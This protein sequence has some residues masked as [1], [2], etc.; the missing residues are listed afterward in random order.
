[1][2]TKGRF[3]LSENNYYFIVVIVLA[4]FAYFPHLGKPPI[5]IYDGAKNAQCAREMYERNNFIVPVFNNELRTDKPPLHL[6][7]MMLGYKLFGV[8]PFSARFFSALFGVLTI[9]SI[10]LFAKRFI[11]IRAAFLTA[12]VLLAS[13]NF[14]LEF[15]WSV[16]DPYLIFFLTSALFS[17][18]TYLQ[19]NEKTF[20][21]LF[22]VCLGVGT[23]AKGP[24]AIALPGLIVI[25]YLITQKRLTLKT[26]F[27]QLQ[28]FLGLFIVTTI[29]LPW[30][31]LVHRATNGAWTYGFFMEHNLQRFSTKK[32][33]HGGSYLLTLAYILIG[34]LPFSIFIFQSARFAVKNFKEPVISFSVITALVFIVFFSLSKTQLPNYPMPAFAFIALLIGSWLNQITV[35]S[36][37][38]IKVSLWIYLLLMLALPGALKIVISNEP[39]IHNLSYL[40]YWFVL[41]PTSAAIALRFAYKNKLSH[42]ISTIAASFIIMNFLLMGWIYPKVYSENPVEKSYRFIDPNRPIAS[43]GKYNPAYNF[44][45]NKVIT[46]CSDTAA[47]KKFLAQNPGAAIISRKTR[48]KELETMG[49]RK[50]AE[51]KDI[52]EP[53]VSAVFIKK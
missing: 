13:M 15:H 27:V 45:L 51:G 34:L 46:I 47:L 21:W 24:V 29:A 22:Y 37:A 48:Q 53:S 16:P 10:Y 50:I 35:Q 42:V 3:N 7:F 39:S 9:A 2:Q 26:L 38:S 4:L 31:W 6:F 52:F 36:V 20:L 33:G 44:A 17:V 19:T 14:T 18:L 1:M 8:T 49:Y 5:Y 32:E 28:P 11:G 30:Y 23:I 41:L 25:I 12:L 43:L 40:S